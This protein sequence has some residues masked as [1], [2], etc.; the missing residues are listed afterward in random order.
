MR[1]SGFALSG[2]EPAKVGEVLNGY[3]LE[4]VIGKGGMG[5]VY[6]ATHTKLPRRAAVKVL[7]ANHATDQALVK[8]FFLEAKIAS[9]LHHPNI[10]E[11]YDFVEQGTPRRVAC[12]MELL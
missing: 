12:V 1:P 10:V 4:T 2:V 7:A 8:R 11:V 3:R 9:E 5:F 6:A